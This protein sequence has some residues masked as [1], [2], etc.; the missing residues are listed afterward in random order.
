MKTISRTTLKMLDRWVRVAGVAA[1]IGSSAA[2]QGKDIDLFAADNSD[3][4]APPNV[5]FLL[6]DSANWTATIGG[7]TKKVLEHEALYDVLSDPDLLPNANG[8]QMRVGLMHFAHSNSP[9]GG[10][11]MAAVK[12]LDLTH[13]ADLLCLLYDNTDCA[14]TRAA[15]NE[16][17]EKTNNAPYALMMNEAYRYFAG[18]SPMSGTAD[19]NHDPDAI[20]A[21]G[22]Y[23]SPQTADACAKNFNI[24]IGN[25][26]PDS[27]EDGDA[28]EKL[29]A[30]GGVL[31][32]DPLQVGK[33]DSF[34]SNWSDEYSRF[35][36]STDVYKGDDDIEREVI[37]YVIDVYDPDSNQ[38]GTP[39]DPTTERDESTPGTRKWESARSWL[40]NIATV[41]GGTY[42]QAHT[43]TD[44][45]DA[46]TEI[47]DEIQSVN[48][49]FASTTLP[50]SVNVRGTNLNQV[51]MGVFRPDGNKKPRWQGNLKLYQ[52]GMDPDTGNIYLADADGNKAE[53]LA[54]GFIDHG[55]RS[56]W[57]HNSV[58]WDFAPSGEPESGSDNP[59]GAVVE[60]GGAHQRLRDK[61]ESAGDH[62]W[63][64]LY[65]CTGDCSDGNSLNGYT[66]DASNTNITESDLGVADATEQSELIAW[67]R[68]ADVD[69]EDSDGSTTDPRPS[70]H[71]DVLHSQPAVIN[72]GD[73]QIVAYYGANDGVFHAVQGGMDEDTTDGDG[74]DGHELWGFIPPEL[75]G[76]LKTLRDNDA[77]ADFGDRP[78]F[79]DGTITALHIDT[80]NDDV[81]D[82]DI[83]KLY[84][85]LTMRRGGRFIYALDVTDYNDPKLLWQRDYQDAGYGE[86]GQTWSAL[87]PITIK[88][89]TSD[90]RH[91]LAF[92]AGYDQPNDDIEPAGT[93]PTY[94]HGRG[95]F[96]VDAA[97]GDIIW[98][99]GHT[100]T[101]S[102]DAG[103][104]VVKLGDMEYSIPSK[105]TTIDRNRDGFDDHIYVGDTGGQVWRVDMDDV[106][107]SNWQVHKLADVGGGDRKRQ[108][109]HRPDVVYTDDGYDAILLGSGDR[110]HPFNETISNRFY[111]FKDTH[112]IAA[113]ES[114]TDFANRG[115]TITESDLFDTTDN[116]I[117]DGTS[118]EQG[119]AANSLAAARGWKLELNTGEKV[120]SSAITLGGTVFFNTHEPA[121]VTEDANCVPNLGIARTY[122]IDFRDAR[123]TVNNDGVAGLEKSDRV[124]K[125]PGG[126]F[127]PSPTPFVVE[128]DGYKV[129]GISVGP[130]THKAPGVE[131]DRRYRTYWYK[132]RD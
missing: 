14:L 125:S 95:L 106:L 97:S 37:T 104:T 31:E 9:K 63:R 102:N 45:K 56:F 127:L 8:T 129:P 82:Q 22:N 67:V 101:H 40:E 117:Q 36:S 12:D 57:T 78:T 72:Y 100:N 1:L 64:N 13:Q 70:I 44:I 113:I 7:T 48:T 128:I 38:A 123:A 121:P 81:V 107:P 26:E 108:F 122:M 68:G 83:D 91:A 110:E 60:K 131:W 98:H 17:L 29:R 124:R 105:V 120:V 92:G 99:A 6:D 62:T 65:T 77:A 4:T 53:N 25:G 88:D 116:A 19:G 76:G 93:T 23:I 32:N 85:Y 33:Y 35:M 118:S 109:F 103:G 59:D 126:G 87:E 27:G 66:F 42:F 73:G 39:D 50:V 15:G 75:F 46:L 58:F 16:A 34:E 71:G 3:Q 89:G 55:A 51:Y 115:G 49:V 11:V 2:A 18:L 10:K 41:S 94:D 21:D 30:L 130:E 84:I 114:A 24:L 119:T 43:A 112:Q 5:L 61:H 20:G 47:M 69:D 90:G 96:V 86:L 80:D 54:T 79:V 74:R 132:E 52:I 28:E 111:M